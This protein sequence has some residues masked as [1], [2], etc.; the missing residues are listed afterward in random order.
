[1]EEWRRRRGEERR[2]RREERRERREEEG[3]GGRG[4][5]GEE[6][7]R[8]KC[9][10]GLWVAGTQ[11]LLGKTNIPQERMQQERKEYSDHQKQYLSPCEAGVLFTVDLLVLEEETL[12]LRAH[13]KW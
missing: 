11:L 3:E 6:G 1:M 12:A 9:L 8:V 10:S 4:E 7:K 13:W 2:E 5:G